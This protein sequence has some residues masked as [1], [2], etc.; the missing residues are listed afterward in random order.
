MISGKVRGPEY[1]GK[2]PNEKLTGLGTK[3]G[4]V[5]KDRTKAPLT[6]PAN[7]ECLY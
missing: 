4:K 2:T 1:D 7:N 3:V 6:F 5:V